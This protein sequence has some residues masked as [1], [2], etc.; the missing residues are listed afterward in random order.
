MGI[1][2]VFEIHSFTLN[3]S[4]AVSASELVLDS[5]LERVS[6]VVF[7]S[8]PHLELSTEVSSSPSGR[9]GTCDE[10]IMVIDVVASSSDELDELSELDELDELDGLDEL[11]EL[12]K[13]DELDELSELDEL[14]ELSELDELDE[15][16]VELSFVS[17]ASTVSIMPDIRKAHANRHV[18]V[19]LSDFTYI[20]PTADMLFRII[21]ITNLICFAPIDNLICRF[22]AANTS[23]R[24]SFLVKWH[25]S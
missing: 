11:D 2:I 18:M 1:H 8:A 21:R 12:D 20:S 5:L 15:L 14:D 13:L 17:V 24:I 16:P 22:S 3:I 23:I 4:F 19:F 6:E 7:T 25:T 10:V 9:Y